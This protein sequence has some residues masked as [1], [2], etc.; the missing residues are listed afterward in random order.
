MQRI[1]EQIKGATADLA[2]SNG[3]YFENIGYFRQCQRN[4]RLADLIAEANE[5]GS[6]LAFK[7]EVTCI[8]PSLVKGWTR[9]GGM[10][11]GEAA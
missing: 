8:M 10:V 9:H 5:H 7:G 3:R 6:V 11:K 2:Q 4:E 1:I